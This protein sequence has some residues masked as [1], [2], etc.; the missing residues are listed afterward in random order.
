MPWSEP[1]K[2]TAT[3]TM[4]SKSFR[5]R[6][7]PYFNWGLGRISLHFIFAEVLRGEILQK[8]LCLLFLQFVRIRQLLV[9]IYIS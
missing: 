4:K 9:H 7:I 8:F 2:I 1:E 6:G 5:F 3:K